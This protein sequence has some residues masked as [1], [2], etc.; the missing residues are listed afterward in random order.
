MTS[1]DLF[2]LTPDEL[3]VKYSITDI[4]RKQNELESEINKKKDEIRVLVG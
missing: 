4:K 3:F 2:V 1:N